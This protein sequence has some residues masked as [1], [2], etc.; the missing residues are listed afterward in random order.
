[1]HGLSQDSGDFS[2]GV[3]EKP[4]TARNGVF[5]W[6]KRGC[7]EDEISGIAGGTGAGVVPGGVELVGVVLGGL[8]VDKLDEVNAGEDIAIG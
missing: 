1:M 2:N 7:C 6:L 4:R 8:H 3:P 5:H